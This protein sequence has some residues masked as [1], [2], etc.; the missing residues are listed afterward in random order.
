MPLEV[1]LLVSCLFLIYS[2]TGCA[3]KN[4]Y[5]EFSSIESNI[6]SKYAIFPINEE[7]DFYENGERDFNIA[8]D[9]NTSFC[10]KFINDLY[11]SITLKNQSKE[12]LLDD[13]LTNQKELVEIFHNA[14]YFEFI[15]V[16]PFHDYTYYFIGYGARSHNS[17]AISSFTP[18]VI[19]EKDSA[20][21]V[22]K[23]AGNVYDA[24]KNLIV[25]QDKDK[26]YFI[27]FD[28]NEKVV[29]ASYIIDRKVYNKKLI[30]NS[31]GIDSAQNSF[32]LSI[33]D[34]VKLKS[35]ILK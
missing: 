9:S 30:V 12:L 5:V 16:I 4:D 32:L 10:F 33:K 26:L 31:L 24:N 19:V 8:V 13:I 18:I 15:K 25:A 21:D 2:L 14:N 11:Y 23:L 35:F 1:K 28:F 7:I 27:T 20:V 17:S 3:Q 29:W 6:E 34:Y 22:F